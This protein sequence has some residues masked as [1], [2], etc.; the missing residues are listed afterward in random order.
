MAIG[1]VSAAA[2]LFAAPV[3]GDVLNR[4]PE[5]ATPRIEA[6]VPAT[7]AQIAGSAIS[8][9]G[10]TGAGMTGVRSDG[11][12]GTRNA[13]IDAAGATVAAVK[14]RKKR[15]TRPLTLQSR[16]TTNAIVTEENAGSYVGVRCPAGTVAI[17]G[18]I[19]SPYINLLI[20]S[21]A[22][23]NPVTGKHTPGTWWVSVTNTNIDGT[24]GALSWRG[25]VNCLSPV[26]LSG[27]VKPSG[28]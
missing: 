11:V 26:K 7:A 12:V 14:P 21:S 10:A 23:N 2:V 13:G 9:D 27:G 17:G 6:T 4:S 22:P 8:P 5:P 18:G 24:G 3:I 16:I 19:I 15:P 1:A 20:S 25:V 28:R